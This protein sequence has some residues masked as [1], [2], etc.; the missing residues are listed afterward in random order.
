MLAALLLPLALLAAQPPTLP[1][2]QPDPSIRDGS[3]Q[4]TLD[5]ARERWREAGVH[6]YRFRLRRQCFC[7]PAA[8]VLFVRRD[9]PR[10]PPSEF[11]GVA[12]VP[13]LFRRI[14][15]AIDDGAAGLR[16]RYGAGRGIPRSIW[17]DGREYIADDEIGYRV[18]RFWRGLKGRGGP[19]Q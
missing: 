11:R 8:P 2:S 13:R 1:P 18:E 4:R 3:A 15:G 5:R 6:S 17:I 7:P 10:R 16:V 12:T 9:R 19:E 14:Q